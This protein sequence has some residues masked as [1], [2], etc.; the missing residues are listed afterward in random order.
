MTHT[1]TDNAMQHFRADEQPFIE[2]ALDWIERATT[3]HQPVLTQFL[4]PRERYILQA[5]VPAGSEVVLGFDGG[6]DG[7]EYMRCLLVPS[8][9]QPDESEMALSFLR[10]TGA[11]K[12]QRLTHKDYLGALLHLG[13]KRDTIGD[14]LVTEGGCDLVTTREMGSFIELHLK[15]VHR[16]HVAVTAIG[17]SALRV[18]EHKWLEQSV[19]V[20]SARLDS[21][22]SAAF[23]LSRS[24]TVSLIRTGKCKL[25][26]KVEENA[27]APVEP[28]DMLSLRGYGRVFVASVDGTTKR[29]RLRLTLHKPH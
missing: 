13:I 5:F 8:Y 6:Y 3:Y 2:R 22:L 23:P 29:G 16:V 19:T 1:H 9:W 4:N 10:V 11:S 7:A 26:W 24:K 12:F 14:L 20:A 18:P 25:N 21:V 15:Q 27:A 17:R 28:G